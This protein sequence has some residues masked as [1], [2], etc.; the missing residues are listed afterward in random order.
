MTAAEIRT[1]V[2]TELTALWTKIQTRQA[3]FFTNRGRYWQGSR[4][5]LIT[6]AEGLPVPPDGTLRPT[7]EAQ[8]WAA[9]GDLP[10]TMSMTVWLDVYDGPGGP[11]YVAHAEVVINGNTW[12][13]SRQHGPETWRT[14]GWAQVVSP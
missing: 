8:G 7:N 4:T 9:L 14:R 12:R 10:L 5:H 2:D 6:P 1:Q 3:T 11:G 13:R